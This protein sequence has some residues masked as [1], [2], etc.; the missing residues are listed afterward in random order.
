MVI[1]YK[2]EQVSP[3]RSDFYKDNQNNEF[4]VQVL[5][6]L[7]VLLATSSGSNCPL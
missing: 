1:E 5:V 3:S 6:L 4:G 2:R 7:N